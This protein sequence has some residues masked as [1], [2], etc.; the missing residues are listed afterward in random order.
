MAMALGASMNSI[1]M[2]HINTII[3]VTKIFHWQED[4]H[5]MQHED[6]R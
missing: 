2:L 3:N 4:H 1:N 5:G 6:V